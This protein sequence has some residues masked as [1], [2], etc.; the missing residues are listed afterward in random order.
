MIQKLVE[1]LLAVKRRMEDSRMQY[2]KAT[3]RERKELEKY[4]RW[5][6]LRQ[7]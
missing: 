4:D 5:L 2:M 7:L 6:R 3:R 1:W